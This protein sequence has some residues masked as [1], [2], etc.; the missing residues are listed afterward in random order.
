MERLV[1][2]Q[3]IMRNKRLINTKLVVVLLEVVY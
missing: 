1:I 2:C 3:V